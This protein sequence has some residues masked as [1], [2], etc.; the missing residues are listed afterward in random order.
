MY[1]NRALLKDGYSSFSLYILEYCEIENLISREQYYLDL[2]APQYNI[3]KVAGSSLGYKHTEE[4]RFKLSEIQK[5]K[6]GE[7][8]Q[9]YGKFHSEETKA[10]RSKQVFVYSNENPSVLLFEFS[11]YTN[12]R[13]HFNCNRQ[14][15]ANNI[16]TKKLFKEKWLLFSKLIT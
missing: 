5:N 4:V 8:H 9:R 1:I 14:T 12:A 16:D 13:K 3:L 10:L 6:K 7:N 2:L 15:I 11:S